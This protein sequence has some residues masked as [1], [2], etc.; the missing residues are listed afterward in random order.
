[1][2]LFPEGGVNRNGLS[3]LAFQL[4]LRELVLVLLDQDMVG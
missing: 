3:I 1:M 4:F 2:Q